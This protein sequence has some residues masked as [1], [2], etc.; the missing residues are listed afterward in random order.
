MMTRKV[1]I[2]AVA[3][4]PG[5]AGVGVIRISGKNLS[6]MASAL[7]QKKLSPRQANLLTLCDE[8]GQAIDQLIA[9][10]FVG[11]AS[12]TGEDVLELQCHGG[13]QL[14]E[15]VMKRCLELG[16]AE[17][18][19][20]AEPGEFTLRAYLNNK[21]D[22][23]QAEAI[24]DLIDAQ[25]E[26]AVRGAARSL[27]GAFSDDINNLIEE[28]TQLRILV[29][30]TLDFPEE[31]IEFLENAQARQRLTAVKEK[32]QALRAG[33][34]QGKILRDG[35]QLVLAGAPN[36]GKSSLLNRLAGEEVAI[37]TPIAGTTRDRVKESITIDGVPMHIIDTA[38]LRETTDVVEAKGIERSWDAIRLADL[39]IFLTDAQSAPQQ[40]GLK[41]QILREIPPKCAVLELVNKADLFQ[42]SLKTTSSE[43]LLI[44]AKTGE[45]IEG[46]KQ[47]ILE[48]VGWAGP[49]EGAILAR[50]RHLDCI[51][52][53]AEHIEKSEEF[54]ANGNNS[55]ELFAEELSLAQRHL[56][57]ITGKL[58]PDDLLGK[59]FSQFCIGK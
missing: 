47:K 14:L 27:Q 8:N 12:F 31:E 34:K 15:L 59:I 29:E 45:G 43:A 22:L 7:F 46:L 20:I 50:R 30:S 51:E 54:A 13:P 42:E 44:S 40:D 5:K 17:G 37:V 48:L 41:T 18:L 58:L 32:L 4:A 36:V 23:T 10:H 55:L 57:E 9:I 2:I 56:G 24:A 35:I 53:A 16:K 28:I 11:P 26:A 52:R 25:S 19:V 33:A 38:G 21:I 6:A 39:V 49:Q 1:P 3:T